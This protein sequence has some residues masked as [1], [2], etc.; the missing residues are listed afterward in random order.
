MSPPSSPSAT[1]HQSS[2]GTQQQQRVVITGSTNSWTP[3]R[4]RAGSSSSIGS[5]GIVTSLT[6]PLLSPTP[7]EHKSS[8]L[9]G[10][11]PKPRTLSRPGTPSTSIAAVHQRPS[12]L[13]EA[14]M[15]RSGVPSTACAR[16]W[17]RHFPLV[18]PL[19]NDVMRAAWVLAALHCVTWSVEP[20]SPQDGPVVFLFALIVQAFVGLLEQSVLFFLWQRSIGRQALLRA[21]AAGTLWGIIY[22]ATMCM[23]L[24]FSSRDYHHLIVLCCACYTIDSGSSVL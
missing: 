6:Q 22:F 4:S 23:F 9:R 7:L 20:S 3:P 8:I 19:Y 10:T 24:P 15:S 5:N 14:T 1:H 16:W 2:N 13:V 12:T 11:S 18:F 21:V 17:R